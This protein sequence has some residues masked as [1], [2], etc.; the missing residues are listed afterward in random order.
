[1][2]HYNE[3]C[4]ANEAF[5]ASITALFEKKNVRALKLFFQLRKY[6]IV[7]RSQISIKGDILIIRTLNQELFIWQH[8]I[9]VEAHCPA[10]TVIIS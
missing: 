2:S 1:M 9:C 4:F 5:T 6:R 8:A 3:P 7:R 10:K